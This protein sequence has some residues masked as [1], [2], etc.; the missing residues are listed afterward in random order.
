[1]KATT[2]QNAEFVKTVLKRSALAVTVAPIVELS[3]RDAVKSANPV[4]M[5][6]FAVNAVCAGTV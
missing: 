2:V 3:V 1:V 5:T 6:S 4:P